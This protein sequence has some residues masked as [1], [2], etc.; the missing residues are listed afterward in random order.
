MAHPAL[1]AISAWPR[2]RLRPWPWFWHGLL[3]GCTFGLVAIFW[4]Y[5]T[6]GLIVVDSR[7]CIGR[8]GPR[9]GRCDAR[10]VS[11]ETIEVPRGLHPRLGH[12]GGLWQ[13]KTLVTGTSRGV[14]SAT[15]CDGRLIEHGPQGDP[16]IAIVVV[17]DIRRVPE[18]VRRMGA[19]VC[20]GV[21]NKWHGDGALYSAAGIPE[22]SSR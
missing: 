4:L 2:P 21:M 16:G 9:R 18:D 5:V 3:L 22:L 10:S 7:L 6:R 20:G 19:R 13:E 15:A 1:P 17:H 8:A 12:E 11:R 14:G